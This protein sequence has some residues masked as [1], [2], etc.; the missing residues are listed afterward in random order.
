MDRAKVLTVVGSAIPDLAETMLAFVAEDEDP[1]VRQ[2]AVLLQRIARFPGM[3]IAGHYSELMADV[4]T[5]VNVVVREQKD[6]DFERFALPPLAGNALQFA[7][8]ASQTTDA[9]GF[10]ATLERY[11]APP[12]AYMRKRTR[13]PGTSGIYVTLNAYVGLSAGVENAVGDNVPVDKGRAAMYTGLAI[14]AGVEVGAATEKS[15]SFG[16]FAQLIDVGQVASWRN[17]QP[18]DAS[19][20]TTPPGLTL[21][22]VFS[23]GVHLVW[24]IPGAPATIGGGYAYAPQFRDLTATLDPTRPRANVTRWT[25]F[26]AI[27]VPLFP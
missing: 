27:D 6:G 15:G 24:N 3:R 14:P 7:I 25:A 12:T 18:A 9:D 13:A 23:P 22:S 5:L 20:K 11:A 21:G 8:D 16:L 4:L 19:V 1:V 2:S 10:A 17:R 26:A